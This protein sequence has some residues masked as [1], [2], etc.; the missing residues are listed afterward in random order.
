MQGKDVA[1]DFFDLIRIRQSV[2]HFKD[3][4][5]SQGDLAAILLAANS[6]PVGSNMNR[7]THLTVVQ[8]RDVLDRLSEAAYKRYE[9]KVMMRKLTEA[10]AGDIDVDAHVKNFDPFYGA[11][12]VIF[13]SHKKDDP[14]PGIE[15]ANSMCVAYTMHLAAADLGLG[16]VF[17]WFALESMR[18]FPEMDNS[19]ILEQP[20]GFEPLIG[21][22][23]GYPERELKTRDIR[24]DKFTSNYLT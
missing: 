21:I 6:A 23:I 17:M 15:F 7:N 13:V 8:R 14:Q 5:I 22:A 18:E 12:T 3:E 24:P 10:L 11:P 20:E 19:H 1:V 9:D 2:R 4:Q 16:S